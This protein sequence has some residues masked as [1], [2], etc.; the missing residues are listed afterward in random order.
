MAEFNTD[1]LSW[2]P[3]TSIFREDSLLYRILCRLTAGAVICVSRENRSQR[4]KDSVCIMYKYIYNYIKSYISVL[5]K[6]DDN[7]CLLQ[8][9]LPIIWKRIDSDA[10]S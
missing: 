8:R 7:N 1:L 3:G 4:D 10:G 2:G 6:N 9:N 5:H